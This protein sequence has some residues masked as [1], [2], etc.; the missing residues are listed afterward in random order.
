MTHVDFCYGLLLR[1]LLQQ[2]KSVHNHAKM[3]L[4][5]N[6]QQTRLQVTQMMMAFKLLKCYYQA[7]L[8]MR[9]RKS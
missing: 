8:L 7:L 2:Q 6:A 4:Q 3:Q 9:V 1:N 5:Q